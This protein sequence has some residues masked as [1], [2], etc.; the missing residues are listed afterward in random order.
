[1]PKRLLALILGMAAGLAVTLPAAAHAVLLRSVPEANAALA[2]APVQIEL[3]FSEPLEASFSTVTVLDTAGQT[4]DARDVRV[5]PADPAHLTV[6]VRSLRDGV[7]TVAWKALSAADG[8]LSTGA[9]PFAVGNVDPSALAAAAPG[10][11]PAEI[12]PE[13]VA[14]KWLLYL[15]TA[16]LLGG[17]LF[18]QWVWRP[19]AH[20]LNAAP[21]VQDAVPSRRGLELAA[22]GLLAVSGLHLLLQAGRVSGSTLALPWSG[23]T[24]GVLLTTRFGALWTARI[25]ATVTLAALLRGRQPRD[26]WLAL[27]VAVGVALLVSLGSHAAAE[28]EPLWPVVADWLH[29]IAMSVWVGGLFQFGRGLWVIR[30]TDAPWRSRFTAVLIP[31]FSVLALGS[32][33]VL[34]LTGLYA[35]FQQIGGWEALVNT[36]YGQTLLVK[37]AL[38]TPLLGLGAVNLLLVTPRLRRA[39]QAGGDRA[40]VDRFRR[41]VFSE[42][43]LS[44]L[45]LLSVGALTSVPPARASTPGA[46]SATAA[47][48]DLQMALAITPG[49]VG[50]NTFTLTITA[51]GRP[52]DD[53][54]KVSLQFTPSQGTVPP[55][56][57]QLHSLGYGQYALKG[58][59]FSLAGRWQVQAIVQ[60]ADKFDAYANYDFDLGGAAPAEAVPWPRAVGALL[61]AT[62]LACLF[63]GGRLSASRWQLL[64]TGGLPGLAL[65]LAGM[66]AV[67]QPPPAEHVGPANPVAPNAASVAAGQALFETNCAPCH[68]P[69][70]RGDGPVGLT[71]SPRPADLSRHAVPGIHTDGQLFE[72][73]SQGFPNS[74]MPAFAGRLAE[75]DR[76]HLVNYLRTLARP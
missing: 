65:A 4:A 25:A 29:L 13:A 67:A 28:A 26:T 21:A 57:G 56:L 53:A 61:L 36:V 50:V 43:A 51:N 22:L 63:L 40:L 52:V 20:Q 32:V 18:G 27:G 19:A 15:T 54:Q 37:L 48:D 31:R 9:F 23:A 33:A 75:T 24:T 34:A 72:W 1:M 49:R 46:L 12:S 73:I 58:A 42:I 55:S 70:G 68:G 74:V 45:V 69:A 30:E 47:A 41:I 8:H 6:S 35:A 10:L 59:F 16:A 76:W 66:L 3:F 39:A 60:R 2:H 38:L 64:I 5:D 62:A 11:A 14:V 7:Y 17:I 71:L 44:A